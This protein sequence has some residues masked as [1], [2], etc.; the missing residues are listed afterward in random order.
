VAVG[1]PSGHEDR[2]ADGC[3]VGGRAGKGG[4]GQRRRLRSNLEEERK[5]EKTSLIQN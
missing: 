4:K 3:G 2:G 5:R 1:A